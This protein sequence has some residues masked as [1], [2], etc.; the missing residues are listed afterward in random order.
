[1][2]LIGAHC[3]EVMY[4]GHFGFRGGFLNYDDDYM[5]VVNKQ[6]ELLEFVSQSVYVYF[7]LRGRFI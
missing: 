5:C 6:F 1:M 3:C 4:F 7:F 2:Q